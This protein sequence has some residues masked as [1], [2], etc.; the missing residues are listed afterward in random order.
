MPYDVSY[1]EF[2]RDLPVLSQPNLHISPV[3]Y[4]AVA[5]AIQNSNVVQ[6]TTANAAGS[7]ATTKASIST[8]EADAKLKL[9]KQLKYPQ[10]D[11]YDEIDEFIDSMEKVNMA[12]SMARRVSAA[13]IQ[14]L[15]SVAPTEHDERAITTEPNWFATEKQ[16]NEYIAEVSAADLNFDLGDLSDGEDEDSDDELAEVERI[17]R[18]ASSTRVRSPRTAAAR[19]TPP[20]DVGQLLSRPAIGGAAAA[21]G[22][23]APKGD[24]RDFF[25]QIDAKRQPKP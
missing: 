3:V 15:L 2:F 7:V 20:S 23:A 22:S 14:E 8:A 11:R 19:G 17:L 4:P 18:K 6:T 21:G 24:L 9:H 5:A 16:M 1:I 10:P 13:K 12:D 25:S